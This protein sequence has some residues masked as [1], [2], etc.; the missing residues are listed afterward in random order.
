MIHVER[1]KAKYDR[2]SQVNNVFR[3]IS[4]PGVKL[5][6]DASPLIL[7]LRGEFLSEAPGSSFGRY[8]S[9]SHHRKRSVFLCSLP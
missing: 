9:K 7:Y 5:L 1:K 3:S 6:E 2:G 4:R 8:A